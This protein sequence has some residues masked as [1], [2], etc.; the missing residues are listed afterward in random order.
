MGGVRQDESRQ[1][2]DLQNCVT[3]RDRNV[4]VAIVDWRE[5]AVRRPSGQ[6]LVRK[7]DADVALGGKRHRLW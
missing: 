3:S 5:L 1:P 2:R 4:T 6:T 7:A